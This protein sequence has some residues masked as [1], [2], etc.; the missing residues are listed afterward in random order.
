MYIQNGNR[1]TDIENKPVYISIEGR[2]GG[3]VKGM[4]LTDTNNCV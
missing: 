3:Q 2:G 4:G 1:V